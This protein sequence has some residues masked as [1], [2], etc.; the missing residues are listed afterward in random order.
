MSPRHSVNP[1][2]TVISATISARF[3]FD[4]LEFYE[5]EHEIWIA[6]KAHRNIPTVRPRPRRGT[7]YRLYPLSSFLSIDWSNE[8]APILQCST[9]SSSGKSGRTVWTQ[10]QPGEQYGPV[11]PAATATA[12][13]L[14]RS[15]ISNLAL[16]SIFSGCG[17]SERGKGSSGSQ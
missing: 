17:V 16:R 3:R 15:T 9:G 13:S 1:N 6:L 11:K 12:A 14:R 8:S 2:S 7:Q 5:H 4:F 10:L